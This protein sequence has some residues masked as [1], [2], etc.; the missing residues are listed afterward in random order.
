MGANDDP[1]PDVD[2][3]YEHAPCALIITSKAGL[4]LRANATFCEWLGYSKDQLVGRRKLQELLTIGGRIF[5]QTHWMPLLEMQ[6]SICEVKLEFATSEGKKLPMILNATRREHLGGIFDEV[7]AFVVIERHRF[8][9]EVLIS[10]RQ[11][12]ESLEAHLALQRDLSVADA[13]LR[14]ALESAKMHVWDVDPVTLERRYDNSVAQLLGYP[15]NQDVSA[16]VYSD[17]IDPNDRPREAE[18]FSAALGS[19]AQEYRCTYRLNGVDGVQRTVLSTGRA[20]FDPNNKLV[21]FVGILHDIT[22]VKREQAAAEDRALFSEQMIGIVSHDLRNPLSVIS[23]ATEVLERNDLSPKQQ[24]LV[25]HTQE[26]AQRARRLINDLLDFTQA[27]IGRGIGVTKTTIDLHLL[28]AAA[29]EQL[30]IVYP[31]REFLHSIN[32][33]GLCMADSDRLTQLAGN[34]ISN[35]VTYGAVDRPVTVTSSITE[36]GFELVVHNWGTPIPPDFLATV[37][38]PMTRGVNLAQDSRSVGLGLFIVREIVKAHGGTVSVSSTI[39]SG[40]AFMATFP[41]K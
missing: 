4:I 38:S 33:Q 21:Q 26:A 9:Q 5:H 2:V 12:E 24:Q 22:D 19:V 13:R 39:E 28:I 41:L 23:M 6:R 36:Q 20:A 30:R 16:S 40:T 10:K 27:R 34:L 17:L 32:G 7:C 35:A 8:E 31:K 18:L 25:R 3:L 15:S 1:L 14:V 11:A 37:F 29:V